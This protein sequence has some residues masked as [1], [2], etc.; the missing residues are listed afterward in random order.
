[1]KLPLMWKLWSH[2]DASRLQKTPPLPGKR[3]RSPSPSLAGM[4]AACRAFLRERAVGGG[5]VLF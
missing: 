2:Q 5:L 3:S 4:G 1:M